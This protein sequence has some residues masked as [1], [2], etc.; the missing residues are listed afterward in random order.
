MTII[1]TAV[2]TICPGIS[3]GHPHDGWQGLEQSQSDLCVVTS[4]ISGPSVVSTSDSSV[5]VVSKSVIFSV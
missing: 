5:A 3:S 4:S 1:G 2:V